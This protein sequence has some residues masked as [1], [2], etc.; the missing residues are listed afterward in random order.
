MEVNLFDIALVGM[1]VFAFARIVGF[2][3]EA[4]KES[5]LERVKA[6]QQN[7]INELYGRED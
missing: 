3:E 7:K 2:I 1:I 6:D 4:E 5:L